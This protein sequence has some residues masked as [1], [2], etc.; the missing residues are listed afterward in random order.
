M[1]KFHR[2]EHLPLAVAVGL[3]QHGLDVTTSAKAGLLSADDEVQ[4]EFASRD[5]RV[6]V[7][8]DH[9]FLRLHAEGTQHAGVAYCH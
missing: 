1:L 9:D 2:D 4:L 3:R 8:H 6:L 5:A 7:H